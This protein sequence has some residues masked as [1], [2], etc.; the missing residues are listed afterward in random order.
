MRVLTATTSFALTAV[1]TTSALAQNQAQPWLGDRRFGGGIGIRTGNFELHPS[2]AG[3]LGYDTNFFQSS[4]EVTPDGVVVLIPSRFRPVFPDGTTFGANGVFNEPK[5]GAF[6]FRLTPSLTLRTLGAQRTEGDEGDSVPPKVNLE[7]SV[8]ASYNELVATDAQYADAVSDNR[9][10]SGDLGVAVDILPYRPWG[11][12]LFGQYNRAVQPVNDP[13]APP[14]FQRSTFRVGGAVKWR[15]AGGL[16]DWSLGYDLTYILFEDEIFSN[17]SSVGN[18]ITLRGRWL[19]LP[20][21][22]LLYA[23]DYGFLDYPEGGRVKPPGS[24]L[25]SQIGINGLVTNHLGALVMAGW[26]TLFFAEDAEF[27][28]FIGNAELTW[29]PLPRPD[30]APEAAGVGLSS[31]SI[32]Y[33]RDARPAYLG[34][35]VQLDGG[36]VEASY[37]FGGRILV[38]VDGSFDHLRRPESFFS[39][40]IRQTAAFSENRMTLTGF[41]E[42]R[43]SDTFGVNTTLRYSGAITDQRIPVDNDPSNPLLPYD[44]FNFNRIEAWLGVRWFL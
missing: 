16:L 39:N 23:G 5:V 20:R 6:R 14:G 30:L 26:K 32:G 27:D 22:A 36:Y 24:P 38:S 18:N 41:A 13:A 37:F 17:F 31:V 21:T 33:R 25:S 40:L 34:N 42:Y 43:T 44:D 12:G 2:V 9:F 19:F 35:Y 11:L 28:S 1:M 3:E 10:I 29:Y 7:A 15:P 8:S 4:G